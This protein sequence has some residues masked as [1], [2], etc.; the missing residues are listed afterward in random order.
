MRSGALRQLPQ[1]LE[2]NGTELAPR[3]TVEK[4]CALAERPTWEAAGTV[5]SLGQTG[6]SRMRVIEPVPKDPHKAS[7]Q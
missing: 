5:C 2:G 4:T 7:I 6:K 3:T 1:D